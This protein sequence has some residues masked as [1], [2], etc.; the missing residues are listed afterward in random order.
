MKRTQQ[1][2][3]FELAT[4]IDAGIPP[5]KAIH[6]LNRPDNRW[7]HAG[8]LIS[9]GK[10]L[11]SA[12]FNSKL[13]QPFEH[14]LLKVSEA[15]GRLNYGLHELAKIST[16][17]E[18]SI[19][20]IKAKLFLPFAVLLV[21][22][23]VS[24]LLSLL[25]QSASVASVI[26]EGVIQLLVAIA[27]IKLCFNV[28]RA[29]TTKKLS[30]FSSFNSFSWYKIYF[31]QTLFQAILWQLDS[32]IDIKSALQRIS[33]LFNKPIKNKLIQVAKQCAKGS[34]LGDA[35][36]RS[37]LPIESHFI[38]LIRT[39]DETGTWSSVLT[40]QL[41]LNKELLELQ[42]NT[43]VEWLPRIFYAMVVVIAIR[44]IL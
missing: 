30:W 38:E 27:I 14:E 42:L 26:V 25:A 40:N 24:T 39:A 16:E 13:I 20:R 17:R 34:P 4:L 2:P 35:L 18:A 36:K 29:D 3:F 43:L 1:S 23:T 33:M 10:T 21:A 19:S 11:S 8:Q 41:K 12:L 28:I 44:T 9:E 37:G 15:S 31:Q 5:E 7:Q 32:G 22:I 6:S